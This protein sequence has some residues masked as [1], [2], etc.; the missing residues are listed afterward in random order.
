VELSSGYTVTTVA[1]DGPKLLF[2][3][4]KQLGHWP[5]NCSDRYLQAKVLSGGKIRFGNSMRVGQVSYITESEEVEEHS[6]C[7][8]DPILSLVLAFDPLEDSFAFFNQLLELY[9]ST[10]STTTTLELWVDQEFADAAMTS[11]SFPA[12][13]TFHSF[14]NVKT[15]N[16]LDQSPL[17]LL[18]LFLQHSSLPDHPLFPALESLQLTG[19]EMDDGQEGAMYSVFVAFLLMRAEAGIPLL[20]IEMLGGYM[21]NE[22]AEDLS[23]IGNLRVSLDSMTLYYSNT[24]YSNDDSD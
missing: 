6:R 23:R 1:L 18:A 3:L 19:T 2:F 8:K 21:T 13:P 9:S 16:L 24:I 22:T 5:Q 12:F 7:S 10:F 4:S 15:L 17:Y 14:T 20:E 11:G